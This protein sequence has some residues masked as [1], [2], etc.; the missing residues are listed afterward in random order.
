MCSSSAVRIE[1]SLQRVYA[2]TGPALRPPDPQHSLR[3]S[4]SGAST[5]DPSNDG[6]SP[7]TS[8]TTV[9]AF[10][11]GTSQIQLDSIDSLNLSSQQ[12]TGVSRMASRAGQLPLGSKDASS[13]FLQ[14]VRQVGQF[15]AL[16]FHV[17]R[18][19]RCDGTCTCVC[20]SRSRFQSPKPLNQFLGA[21]FIGYA[22]LPVWT[23]N[24]DKSDCSNQY[25]RT[26]QVSYSFPM[27]LLSKT[28]DFVAAMTYNNEPHIGL[29]V[30]NR[31]QT[32]ENSIF[33]FARNG[34]LS[35]IVESFKRRKASPNDLSS[36]TGETILQ[37]SLDGISLRSRNTKR[38]VNFSKMREIV[39]LVAN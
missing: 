1:L 28:I 13:T 19:A 39:P 29:K 4:P 5:N 3:L 21:L 8:F 30:R 35:G 15:G 18:L 34:N 7:P 20:H 38:F 11:S 10:Q 26:L 31:V 23:R 27:W 33:T 24:C 9:A 14:T 12:S 37:V 25:S 22:G 16:T 2:E 17:H 36:R 32:T 6:S